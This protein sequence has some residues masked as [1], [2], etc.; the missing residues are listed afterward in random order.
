MERVPKS[1][2]EHLLPVV[3][4][5]DDLEAVT[6]VLAEAGHEVAIVGQGFSFSSLAELSEKCA[7]GPIHDL[8]LSC[9]DPYV[10]LELNSHQIWLHAS[11]DGLLST[12]AFEKIR[13]VLAPRFRRLT[14]PSFHVKILPV[15]AAVLGSFIGSALIS[16]MYSWAAVATVPAICLVGLWFWGY[17]IQFRR[18]S[19]IFLVRR[20]TRPSFW[21]RRH[22]EIVLA[23]I[24]ALLGA[25]ATALVTTF[26]GSR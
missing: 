14:R 4:H 19:T 18:Y 3:L 8:T 15:L 5:L 21:K 26:I 22:D 7:P 25:L 2:A 23:V 17:N 12:G 1:L 13:N 10:S 9:R 24:A 6:N 20:A 11:D 16:E